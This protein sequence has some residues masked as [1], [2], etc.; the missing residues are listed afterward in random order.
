MP[1][2]DKTA[3]VLETWL[4]GDADGPATAS[5][6]FGDTSPGGKLPVTFP[7]D[8]TQGPGTEASEYP[9][10]TET[11]GALDTAHFDEGLLVGYRYWDAHK[12]RPLFEFGYGLSYTKFS[13]QALGAVA[14]PGGGAKVKVRV[15]N[16]GSR[17]GSNVVQVYVGFPVSAGEPP[18]Q[19]KAFRKVFLQPGEEQTM[20]LDLDAQAFRQWSATNR[21]WV[22]AAGQYQLRL[23]D[24]SRNI[25]WTTGMTLQGSRS[26]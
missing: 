25:T 15:K 20:Q 8:E 21:K 16:V 17:E 6:L 3:A 26:E 24:S 5:L 14:V 12:Q 2:L 10:T 7:A 22:V 13:I 18:Q 11:N 23:G 9:G 4:P 1:W 19:L